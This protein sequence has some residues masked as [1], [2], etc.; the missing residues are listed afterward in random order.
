M[1]FVTRQAQTTAAIRRFLSL[2]L[3]PV[4]QRRGQGVIWLFAG[5]TFCLSLFFA[6]LYFES[7]A[8]LAIG[9]AR[10][11]VPFM[12]YG[13][14][15]A[16]QLAWIRN[17]WQPGSTMALLGSPIRPLQLLTS[18]L[19]GAWITSAI[20]LLFPVLVALSQG[21]F[22]P[23]RSA[24]EFILIGFAA[25][26]S[27]SA[28]ACLDLGLRQLTSM[29]R[30]NAILA[31]LMSALL[32][33]GG[34]LFPPPDLIS[35]GSTAVLVIIPGAAQFLALPAIIVAAVALAH[36]TAAAI[37]AL[38]VTALNPLWIEQ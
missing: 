6:G 5:I 25:M 20:I 28:I 21:L 15:V 2:A 18:Q 8:P 4:W 33:L 19:L 34:I 26:A 14:S 24:W 3:L 13:A 36:L 9:F 16:I 1:S 31:L 30:A 35:L 7:K 22:E 12:L 10:L 23:D 11:V 38:V 29:Q 37:F 17:Q 32:G 27:S